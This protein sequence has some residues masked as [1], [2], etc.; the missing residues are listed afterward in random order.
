MSSSNNRPIFVVSAPRSGSTLFRLVLDAHPNIAVPPPA[1]L[2]ELIRPFVYSYGTPMSDENFLELCEDSLK[3]PTITRWNLGV[4]PATVA[5]QC[6]TKD[7]KGI[8][9]LLHRIYA[10]STGKQRWGEK[11]PRNSFWIDE[12]LEDFPDAQFLHIVRDGRDMA[13]DIAD[14]P[15]MRPYSLYS[16]ATVWRRYVKAIRE[17][18]SRLNPSQFF[19]V[20]YEDMCAD[21]EAE[22]KK[23]CAFLGED[24]D[25]VMLSHQ[26][27]SQ[28]SGWASDPQHAKSGRPITTDYCEM[29]KAR[30]STTDAGH[31]ESVFADLLKA[32]DYPLMGPVEVPER[33]ASQVLQ[34]DVTT[35]PENYNYKAELVER[36]MARRER[37]VYETE[38]LKSLLLSLV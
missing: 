1:W 8:F 9:S 13:I 26:T 17:S 38:N 36:R 34:S 37:G 18:A 10:D 5:S 27:S 30:L 24:Y 32:Y 25:S 33:W 4:D 28:A 12:I 14:S 7:F 3:T 20:K 22:L 2:Y 29:Y 16:G 15:Q 19:E 11:T 35:S 23:V 6:E 21:P 31:L